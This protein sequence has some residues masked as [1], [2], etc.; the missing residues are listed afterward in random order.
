MRT[1]LATASSPM[2]Q[3]RSNQRVAAVQDAAVQLHVLADRRSGGGP[4]QV[5]AHGTCPWRSPGQRCNARCM[6]A[7]IRA[8]RSASP[9]RMAG[10]GGSTRGATASSKLTFSRRSSTVPATS[11]PSRLN[12]STFTPR[13]RDPVGVEAGVDDAERDGHVG[14]RL[15]LQRQPAVARGRP[16]DDGPV[17]QV[18]PLAPGVHQEQARPVRPGPV[19]LAL[20]H[21][22]GRHAQL[23]A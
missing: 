15:P 12:A 14:G 22:L 4:G 10:S 23:G 20:A 5:H 7:F 16:I 18:Q 2:S 11:S 17:G 19:A 8:A 21:E 13:P 6:R 3:Q 1:L 9:A